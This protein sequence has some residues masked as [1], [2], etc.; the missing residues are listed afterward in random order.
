MAGVI[1][2]DAMSRAERDRLVQA[3]SEGDAKPTGAK[4][5]KKPEEE[6]YTP[7][8]VR[9]LQVFAYI[10]AYTMLG[11]GWLLTHIGQA[12]FWIGSEAKKGARSM[13]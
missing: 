13:S 9:P 12:M 2:V 5:E 7:W 11:T 6:F 8:Y 10:F 1:R 4:A 3:I